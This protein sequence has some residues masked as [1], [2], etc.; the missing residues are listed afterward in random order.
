MEVKIPEVSIEERNK[1]LAQEYKQHC[2][3]E[4]F[5]EP[6]DLKQAFQE[7]QEKTTH[8][9]QD[10]QKVYLAM[11][12]YPVSNLQSLYGDLIRENKS[13]T[14]YANVQRYQA[15]LAEYN[16]TCAR[17]M[18]QLTNAYTT[19][20]T[21]QGS[22]PDIPQE[23]KNCYRFQQLI[24]GIDKELRNWEEYE[25]KYNARKVEEEN[26]RRDF[27]NTLATEI[28]TLKKHRDEL[29]T[30]VQNLTR[31][32]IRT[33]QSFQADFEKHKDQLNRCVAY[34]EFLNQLG[35]TV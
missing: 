20:L 10:Y 23:T 9:L 17:R 24:P 34:K 19:Y 2:E 4:T 7:V 6:K 30:A 12:K 15:K 11:N 29:G 22:F 25:K 21:R 33:E 8:L 28:N 14:S 35:V 5:K 3:E 26:K 31:M 18:Q 16:Q 13:L 32:L 1:A 27:V